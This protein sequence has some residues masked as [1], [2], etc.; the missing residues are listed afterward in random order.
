M[1]ISSF[2]VLENVCDAL[3]LMLDNI[4]IRFDFF[5]FKVFK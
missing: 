5:L 1:Y 2:V 3:T 4:F